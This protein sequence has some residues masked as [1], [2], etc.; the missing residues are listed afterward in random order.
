MNK[1]I[2]AYIVLCISSNAVLCTPEEVQKFFDAANKHLYDVLSNSAKKSLLSKQEIMDSRDLHGNSI[3]SAAIL[4]YPDAVRAY[5][6]QKATESLYEILAMLLMGLSRENAATLLNKEN[7]EGI[8]PLFLA[9]QENV[10]LKVI[11]LLHNK[12]ALSTSKEGKRAS[13][14]S[15]KDPYTKQLLQDWENLEQGSELVPRAERIK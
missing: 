14:L 8:T 15:L 5:G 9:V 7:K 3:I 6:A 1:L 2:L 10:P 4:A 13:A 12:G 11:V